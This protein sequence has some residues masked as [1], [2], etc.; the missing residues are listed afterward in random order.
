MKIKLSNP[1]Y[2]LNNAE[3][4]KTTNL[5]QED[6]YDERNVRRR[7]AFIM[8]IW[9]YTSER[10]KKH[11]GVDYCFTEVGHEQVKERFFS[12]VAYKKIAGVWWNNLNED[13]NFAS[14]LIKKSETIITQDA[15]NLIYSNPHRELSV[16]KI[17]D[18]IIQLIEWN[19]D[20]CELSTWGAV[21]YI[22]EWTD[23]EIKDKWI[24]DEQSLSEFM[25]VIY[26]PTKIFLI[27]IEQRDL[28]KIAK[29]KGG[30]FELAL[31]KHCDKYRHIIVRNIDED[32]FD[33][34]HYRKSVALVQN[35]NEYNKIDKHLRTIEEQIE[36]SNKALESSR[37]S[38][39][40]KEKV[41][42]IKWFLYYRTE[43][44]DYHRIINGTYKPIFLQISRIFNIPLDNVANMTCGEIINGLECGMSNTQKSLI[45]ERTKH[46]YGYVVV[47]PPY[48]SFLV[49]GDEIDKVRDIF[50]AKINK[51]QV[52]E[53]RGQTAFKGNVSGVARVITDKRN[54]SELKE[55]EIIITP[56]TSPEFFLGIKKCKGIV[57]NDG[58]ITCHAAI[59]AR[60]FKK[61]CIIGTKVATDIIKTG[62][63][64]VLDADHGIVTIE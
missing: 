58:G 16:E 64:I 18:Y 9:R 6:V 41:R 57:T 53:L 5:L 51:D 48:K 54:A 23:K 20:A 3:F 30:E 12:S 40:L 63:R 19:T 31:K 26:Q 28:L 1:E 50:T 61:P 22:K 62:Q 34:S 35:E 7:T 27:N 25:S 36:K 46:G 56:M 13:I 11:W 29:L 33:I 37:L 38:D 21:D 39:N 15:N 24:R 43:V 44:S 8:D 17:K 42:F 59:M 55:D 2:S 52:K 45:S 60:E 10:I 32:S 49:I 14:E 4:A 47:P